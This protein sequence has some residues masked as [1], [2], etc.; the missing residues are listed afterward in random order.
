MSSENCEIK[1]IISRMKGQIST[2]SSKSASLNL[3]NILPVIP[4]ARTKCAMSFATGR[5]SGRVSPNL[6]RKAVER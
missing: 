5:G 1:S 6:T 3:K 2:H 4:L